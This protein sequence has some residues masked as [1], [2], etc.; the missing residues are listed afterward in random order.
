M[1]YLMNTYKRFDICIVKGEGAK[2][3]DDKGKEYID[4]TSGIGVSSLGYNNPKITNAIS[5]QSKKVMHMS[6]L[7]YNENDEKLAEKICKATGMKNVFFANSGAEANEGAIKLAR[8]YSSNKY[9]AERCE[10][11]TLNN[12]F[13]G[14]TIATLKATGQEKFHKDFSPF[15]D[16]FKY[17]N[18]DDIEDVKS[19]IN[20]KT[21]AI[22]IEIIQGEGGVVPLSKAFV[23]DIAKICEEKDILLIIDEVQTGIGRCGA[24]CA[25]MSYGI[26][27]DIFTLAK[28]L[29]GGI[30]IGA[31]VAGEKCEKT[32]VYSD[33]G[34]TFGGNPLCTAVGNAVVDTMDDAFLSEITKKGEYLKAKLSEMNIPFVTDVRGMGLMIGIGIDNSKLN[35]DLANKIIEK[36]V[37]ILTAGNNALRMLPPLIIGYD[38]IGTAVKII[39]E[40]LM[41]E[42]K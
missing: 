11:I 8:K 3:W 4:L 23:S 21:C 28:G 39:K 24:F 5:E 1:G 42:A 33:H 38:E 29:G 26:K 20:D 13:H 7:F 31:V 40:T 2:V 18:A 10:I 34:S 9:S 6:N 41:E 35:S 25:F 32:F 14:R 15:P 37:L 16:G 30:P 12:S 19:K 17:A 36:G 27:P 22:M